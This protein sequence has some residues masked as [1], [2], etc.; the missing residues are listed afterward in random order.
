MADGP[1]LRVEL[2]NQRP[3]ELLDLTASLTALGEA[4]QDYAVS[5][6]FD[7]LEGNVKLYI[8]E[9]RTGSIVADLESLLHQAS[10]V[11]DHRELFAA[12][13]GN[14]N[15]IV[16]FFLTAAPWGSK[17]A[18]PRNV[19]ERLSQVFEP[20]AKDGGS[21]LFLT[22]QGDVHL[23]T[24]YRYGSEQANVFQNQVRKFYGPRL[25]STMPFRQEPLT[26]VQV[27]DDAKSTA[28]DRGVIERFSGKPVRL[29]FTNEEAKRRVLDQPENP[30]RLVF[31]VDGEM[32]TA[33]GEK[34]AVY[35][36]Q[37]V[38]ASFDRDEL[39]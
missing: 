16:S 37:Y 23:H 2:K 19:A 5:H 6:G 13:L 28:G 29:L 25:P 39:G 20:I 34:P 35:K 33:G 17:E 18:P 11:L 38:H 8:R 30:F 36:I 32:S 10:F 21:Q 14:F 4:Y 31:I 27:R 26:L 3:V 12:F 1:F 7:P 15:E 22:I 9:L 24:D